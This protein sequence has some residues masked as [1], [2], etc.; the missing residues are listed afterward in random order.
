MSETLAA[1]TKSA[2]PSASS[3]DKRVIAKV[4]KWMEM[5]REISREQQGRH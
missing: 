3:A 5:I 2:A 4:E 1:Q